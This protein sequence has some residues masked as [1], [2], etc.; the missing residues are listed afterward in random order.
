MGPGDGSLR[1][2]GTHVADD[3]N[4]V[5]HTEGKNSFHAL[6]E[7]GIESGIGVGEA[8]LLRER[9]GAL[10]ET[11]KDKVVERAFGGELDRGVDS[12][13][14]VPGAAAD[15]YSLQRVPPSIRAE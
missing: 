11:F 2:G 3:A 14:R 13:S 4:A 1:I 8:G 12:V 10:G 15:S 6:V 9:D 5:L 7:E